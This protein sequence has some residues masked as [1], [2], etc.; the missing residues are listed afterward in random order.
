[1]N[2]VLFY[3]FMVLTLT[4]TVAYAGPIVEMKTNLGMI[5]IELNSDKAPQT[6]DNFIK[7]VQNGFYDGTIYHRVIGGFMIQGGGFDQTGARKETLPP[8]KNEADNGLKNDKGTIAM[9]RT[10]DINSATSQF[11]INLVDN[12]FL[13]HTGPTARA[14]GYAVFGK[15]IEGMD[16]VEKIGRVKTITKSTLFQDYPESQVIIETVRL[17]N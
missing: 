6:V 14:F 13:N 12:K 15:V 7:Y 1:M 10:S 11:F 17:L 9:A 3:L 4:T 8:I 16:V 2:K 5:K